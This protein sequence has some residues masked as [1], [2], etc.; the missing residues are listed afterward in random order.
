[1]KKKLL[2]LMMALALALSMTACGGSSSD[3]ADT[4]DVTQDEV[5]VEDTDT[6]DDAEDE[7]ADVEKSVFEP[8]D[9]SDETI[10]SIE[11]YD[12]YLVM[13][14]AIINDYYSNYEEA[15]KGTVLYDEATFQELKDSTDESFEEQKK[16]YE[17]M[18]D[19]KIV[20]KDDLVDYLKEY[21]DSLNE[22]VD[23]MKDA[24]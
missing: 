3:E 15:L 12:D 21:R 23:T 17:S 6:S 16:Q 9:V 19:K 24:L 10:E 20:R 7:E 18:G 13:Y 22:Y 2:A 11:T 5:T 4:A 8:K 14:E 1:M